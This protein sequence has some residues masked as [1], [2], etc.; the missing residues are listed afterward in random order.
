MGIHIDEGTDVDVDVDV[1]R[2]GVPA[3]CERLV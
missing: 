2:L 3:L 1:G